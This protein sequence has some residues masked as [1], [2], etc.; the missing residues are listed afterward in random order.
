[1]IKQNIAFT[2]PNLKIQDK[3]VEKN[4]VK[5]NNFTSGE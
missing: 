3:E 2:Y 5:R 1:M 4:T